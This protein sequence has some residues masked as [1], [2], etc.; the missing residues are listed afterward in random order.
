MKYKTIAILVFSLISTQAFSQSRMKK[1]KATPATE[2][3][4]K[5]TT[6]LTEKLSLTDDQVAK[7]APLFLED[8]KKKKALMEDASI[9]TIR[10]KM[11]KVNKETTNNLKSVLTSQ[12]IQRYKESISKEMREEFMAWI[13]K[14]KID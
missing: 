2:M 13:D 14:Q 5:M 9:F 12:Q 1:M 6:M 11:K 10:G 7:V 4:K 3:A 8:A